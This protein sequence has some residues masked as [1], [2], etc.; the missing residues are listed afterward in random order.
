VLRDS[1][2][3]SLEEDPDPDSNGD[4]EEVNEEDRDEDNGELD[5]NDSGK[6]EEMAWL[7]LPSIEDCMEE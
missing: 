3:K 5:K 6:E 4:E 2:E 1:R 7:L